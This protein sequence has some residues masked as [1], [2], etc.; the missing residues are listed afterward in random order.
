MLVLAGAH[1][2]VSGM[3]GSSNGVTV[4]SRAKGSVGCG[5]STGIRNVDSNSDPFRKPF[6]QRIPEL[7]KLEGW[8]E[9][10]ATKEA[11]MLP[12]YRFK[13]SCRFNDILRCSSF[14]RG[15][16]RHFHSCFDNSYKGMGLRG[17]HF[18]QPIRRCYDPTWAIAYVP[19]KHGNFLGRAWIRLVNGQFQIGRVYGNKLLCNDV[20][21]KLIMLNYNYDCQVGVPDTYLESQA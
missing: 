2:T 8:Y 14:P 7:L 16:P 13:I 11:P 17:E 15:K 19:D 10:E 21:D 3:L 1:N 4:M 12:A 5:L 9:V 6:I 20:K 18:L